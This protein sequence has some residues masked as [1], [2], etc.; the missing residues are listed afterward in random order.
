MSQPSS[1]SRLAHGTHAVDLRVADAVF[2]LLVES[3]RDYAIF[4]LDREGRVATW[5]PGAERIKGYS[6]DEIVGKH[7]SVFYPAADVAA[8]KCEME[9]E[10]AVREGRFEEEGWRVRKDGSLFWASVTITALRRDGEVIGFAK[11][12]RDLTER[13]QAEEQARRFRLLVESVKD[14]AIFILQPD[15]CVATWNIGAE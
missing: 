11:V 13:K 12:T 14:Y 5:N 6:A 15:G 9:L 4:V 1:E 10:T 8:G 2:R 7:F 3:V